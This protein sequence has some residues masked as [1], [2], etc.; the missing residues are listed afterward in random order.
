MSTYFLQGVEHV[1]EYTM[2]L[3]FWEDLTLAQET[4][5]ENNVQKPGKGRGDMLTE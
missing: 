3:I 2:E 5:L 1:K 4:L